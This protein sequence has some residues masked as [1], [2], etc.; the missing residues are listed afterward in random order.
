MSVGVTSCLLLI[1][2]RQRPND[3]RTNNP[4]IPVQTTRVQN[5]LFTTAL[6]P[7]W[8][9]SQWLHAQYFGAPAL[10]LAI[11]PRRRSFVF[12]RLTS[13][14]SAMSLFSSLV[15]PSVI[16]PFFL[17]TIPPPRACR[18]LWRPTPRLRCGDAFP[19]PRRQCSP[20]QLHR[21]RTA[22]DFLPPLASAALLMVLSSVKRQTR[23]LLRLA[24]SIQRGPR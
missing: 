2:C 4:R 1:F 14:T 9:A 7:K 11:A 12:L 19:Y 3:P 21:L 20:V 24:Q 6:C 5:Y 16:V 17:L 15:P 8:C 18:Q 13:L 22:N 10:Q 23:S